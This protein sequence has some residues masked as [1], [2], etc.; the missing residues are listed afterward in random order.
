MIKIALITAVA[1]LLFAPVERANAGTVVQPALFIKNDCR[2]KIEDAH[3][4][5]YLLKRK[6]NPI[7]AL[8]ANLISECRY[9]QQ[10]VIFQIW[11][12]KKVKGEWVNHRS[13]FKYANSPLPNPYYVEEKSAYIK[14]KNR[15]PTW[16]QIKARAWTTIAGKEYSSLLGV[17]Q[18][19]KLLL[20]NF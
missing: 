8:K 11:F 12:V 9:A 16:W 1:L 5:S 18:N 19:P 10:R 6:I 4:S 2:L 14:C 7:R 20:C 17:S 3:I 15:K 13:M